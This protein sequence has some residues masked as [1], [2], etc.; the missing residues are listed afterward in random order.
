MSK[1]TEA[2]KVIIEFLGETISCENVTVIKL[3]RMND[4]W[5]AI[6]EVYEDDSFLKSMNLP[7]KKTRIF[8]SVH[9]DENLEVSAYE[10]I[11]GSDV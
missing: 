4:A 11:S 8:Y 7:P 10:R 3:E 9:L 1:I 5:H 2:R 6:A